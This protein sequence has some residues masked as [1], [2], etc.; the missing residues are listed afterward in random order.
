MW[1]L[2][3]TYGSW[4]LFGI[5]FLLMMRMHS[6]GMHGHG[7]GHGMGMGHQQDEESSAPYRNDS[8]YDQ[9]AEIQRVV[10][11]EDGQRVTQ[12]RDFSMREEN[13]PVE[14]PRPERHSG[15]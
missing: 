14:Y 11:L 4:I 6:G 7:G 3:Q 13:P 8:A 2:L 9:Q 10:P 12:V 1:Q 5:V 15:C